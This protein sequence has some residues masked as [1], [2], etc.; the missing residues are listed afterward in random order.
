[1]GPGGALP[2]GSA[3]GE[4]VIFAL[5]TLLAADRVPWA[6]RTENAAVRLRTSA[7]QLARTANGVAASGRMQQMAVLH[8]DAAELVKRAKQLTLWAEQAEGG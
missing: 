3:I 4:G 8:S 6:D 5:C 2:G 7:E 1:M